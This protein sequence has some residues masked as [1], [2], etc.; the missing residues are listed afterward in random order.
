M[1]KAVD[2]LP[3]IGNVASLR[4]TA[5]QAD[6]IFKEICVVAIVSFG[7]LVGHAALHR[8]ALNIVPVASSTALEA[9]LSAGN[10]QRAQ[11]ILAP[12]TRSR[13]PGM[14]DALF[15]A[16]EA[17]ARDADILVVLLGF[18]EAVTGG[19]ITTLNLVCN[20]IHITPSMAD[21][22]RAVAEAKALLEIAKQ[23][24]TGVGGLLPSAET[25]EASQDNRPP[26]AECV[27]IAERTEVDFLEV[28]VGGVDAGKRRAKLDYGRLRRIH[29]A[30][31]IPLLLRN[32]GD[33]PPAQVQ[34]IDSPEPDA[35]LLA[36]RLKLWGSAGRAAEV[37][38]QCRPLEPVAHVVEFNVPA[39]ALPKLEDILQ[40]GRRRRATIPGVR[41]V[42]TGEAVAADARYRYCLIITFANEQVMRYYRDHPLHVEYADH[43]FR[44]IAEDRVTI[45]F[46]LTDGCPKHAEKRKNRE[47]A[48]QGVIVRF[49]A[50]PAR[51][52]S[53]AAYRNRLS[54]EGEKV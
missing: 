40:T 1:K 28:D 8:Y 52:I 47:Q 22:P 12:M 20:A 41:R 26:V 9:A 51:P 23:C 42:A 24:G 37:L 34:H 54:V 44:P 14:M 38:T 7:D 36:E 15:A 45:D 27:A 3:V 21:F 11:L 13:V 16:C 43:H 32:A 30:L 33:E 31:T 35:A 19:P 46:R 5:I 18:R 39:D 6:A 10:E 53:I 17:V 49:P 48:V 29:E 25:D 4:D 50:S 2:L